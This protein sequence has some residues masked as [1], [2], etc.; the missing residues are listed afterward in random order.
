VRSRSAA[1]L[2]SGQGFDAASLSGG[3][4]AWNGLVSEAGVDQGMYL[5]EGGES[6]EE[7][8]ALAYGLEEGAR[9]FYETLADRAGDAEVK[10]LFQT[11]AGIEVRHEDKIWDR[12][13]ELAGASAVRESFAAQNVAQALEGGLTSDQVVDR[14]PVD[15]QTAPKALELAMALETDALDLYLRMA[16]PCRDEGSKEVFHAIAQEERE[17][18]RK[19]GEM[20]GKRAVQG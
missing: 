7:S 6:P 4:D 8:L 15:L 13:R 17:H 12:Y 9:R 14:Y 5:L 2:L 16:Q 1:N 19:L 10:D 18:L 20:L 3:I 11:L